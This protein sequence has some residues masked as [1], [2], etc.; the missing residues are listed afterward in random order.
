MLGHETVV[1]VTLAA[2]GDKTELTLTQRM[3][4]SV[5]ARDEHNRG[6]SSAL[7]CLDEYLA[8]LN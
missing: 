1:T 3:F 6:W 4:E 5:S 2:R 8:G 7:E